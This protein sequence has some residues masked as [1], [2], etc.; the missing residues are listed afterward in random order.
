MLVMSPALPERSVRSTGGMLLGTSKS[1][2]M[3][4]GLL[5]LN[6]S[7]HTPDVVLSG[8]TLPTAKRSR[9]PGQ[10]TPRRKRGLL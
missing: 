5:G 4:V 3:A 9:G 1:S 2:M 7:L 6:L 10:M 8:V